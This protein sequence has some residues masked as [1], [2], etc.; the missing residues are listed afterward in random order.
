MESILAAAVTG[1]MTLF[2]VLVSNARSKAVIECKLD[3]LSRRVELHNQVVERVYG[4][5]QRTS[6][7]ERDLEI[8]DGKAGIR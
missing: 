3:E 6:L 1:L 7:I 8:L 4:L 5:E 2:G